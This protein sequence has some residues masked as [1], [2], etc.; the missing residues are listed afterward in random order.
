MTLS[1]IDEA[2]E[3]SQKTPFDAF[4][5]E[6]HLQNT[7]MKTFIE[8]I[9]SANNPLHNDGYVLPILGLTNQEKDNEE[10]RCLQ[11]GMNYYIDPPLQVDDLRAILRRWIG[12]SIDMAE[13]EKQRLH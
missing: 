4:I 5:T 8:R 12:R 10:T 9:K 11:C 3:H 1:S 6:S 2:I 13:Q 7:D